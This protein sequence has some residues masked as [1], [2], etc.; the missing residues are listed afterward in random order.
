[1]KKK[2]KGNYAFIDSQNLYLGIKSQG[3]KLDYARFRVYLK[4]KYNVERAFLFIGYVVGHDALYTALQ[5]AGY[6][7]I[8]KPTLEVTKGKTVKIKGNVDTELVLRA[9]IE[10]HRYAQ[11]IIVSGDG[12]FHC[13]VQYFVGKKKPL[14]LMVPNRKGFSALLRKF[15]KYVVFIDQL[16]EKIKE[17]HYSSDEP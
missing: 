7:I 11:A 6:I 14:V 9:M 2:I 5:K 12:D 17:G 16:K 15:M 10:Y 3:W 1:M 4:D 8:F 13:L